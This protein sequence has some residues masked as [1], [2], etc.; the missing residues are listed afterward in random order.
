MSV[1]PHGL[2]EAEAAAR[3]ASGNDNDASLRPRRTWEMARRESVFTV[4]HLNLIG[5]ILIQVL[6]GEWIGALVTFGMMCL[7]TA[8]R[9]GQEMLAHRRLQAVRAHT[10][11]RAS[12]VRDGRTRSIDSDQVV[13]GDLLLIGPGDQ[14]QVDGRVVGPAT[15]VV[16][17]S[18][19]TGRRGWARVAEGDDVFAGSVCISGRGSYLAERVGSDRLI[20]ARVLARTRLASRPTPLERTVARILG[21]LFAVVFVYAAILVA[22]WFRLEV[23]SGLDGLVNAAPVIFGLAPTGLYLMIIVTYATGTADLARIGALVHSARSVESLAESTVLCFTEVGL[24]SGTAME[25]VPLREADKDDPDR[26]STSQLRQLLGDFARSM[27]APG[28]ISRILVRSFEGEP[29]PL[30][31][32]SSHL[33]ELGWT[34]LVFEDD[35]GVYVLAEPRLLGDRLAAYGI[36]AGT[37]AGGGAGADE[38]ADTLILAR[39]HGEVS[40]FDDAGT[41][42]LPDGLVPLCAVRYRRLMRPEALRVVR[43]FVQAGVRIKVFAVEDAPDVVS[44]LREAG[45]SSADEADL[46]VTGGLSGADL[47][48]LPRSEWGRVVQEH[49]LFGGLSPEQIGDLIRLLRDRG[50]HVTVVGDGVTDLPALQEA[51][52]AVAQPASTQAALGLAD[53][54][55]LDN[56]PTALLA[57]LH[58]G[59]SIVRGLLNVIQLN[60]TLVLCSALLIVEV[61]LFGVGFPYLAGQGSV[62]SVLAIT[63]PS[64]AMSFLPGYGSVSSKKY[65][66]MLLRFV[67]PAGVTLSVAAFCVYVGF[68]SRL[69]VAIAQLAVMYT[70]LY[71]LLTLTVLIKPPLRTRPPRPGETRPRR[72]WR[73]VA[74]AGALAL[75]GTLLPLV[76]IARRQFRIDL[77]PQLSDYLVVWLVVAGWVAVLHLI[78]RVWPRADLQPPAPGDAAASAA[79]LGWKSR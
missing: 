23:G 53:I 36:D 65:R 77:L 40:L 61:R 15:M 21:A 52:L 49:R 35:P 54:V 72:E 12:V 55:L 37:P 17:T 68:H 31:A 47:E 79:R 5:L 20:H 22:K 33:A 32:D 62:I 48:A 14:F 56:A 26:P 43:G 45:L 18:V 6:L 42:R 51:H 3:L 57:V 41:P 4:F 25:L 50:E 13:V 67:V 74:L 28:L 7:T 46:L 10:Q 39:R 66:L 59:Q 70:L 63:I 75:I 16:D 34:A 29:R 44:A 76:P 24:L 30:R 69:G 11:A 64:L 78:W 71:A 1:P 58:R 38:V 27:P 8:L 19:V 73:M 2:T 9:V 60:L